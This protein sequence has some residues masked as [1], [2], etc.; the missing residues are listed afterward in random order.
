MGLKI[1]VEDNKILSIRGDEEDPFSKGHIC[2]KAVALQDIHEDPN[3][4]KHPM[5]RTAE[6]WVRISWEEAFDEVAQNLRNLREKYGNNALGIYKGNPSVHHAGTL[7][8]A[9]PFFRSIRSK[10]NFS[11]TSVDQLPH[12]MASLTMLGHQLLT[13]IPDIDRTDFM[14]ILGANPLVSNGSLMSAPGYDKRLKALQQRGGK[15]VVID[16]RRTETAKK[17]DQ[18]IFIKPGSDALLLLSLLQV[19]YA[20]NLI[21]SDNPLQRDD[22]R[23]GNNPNDGSRL[24]T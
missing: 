9:A 2:P 7:L 24:C 16:P 21:P 23:L 22:R 19:L 10:N 14:L 1:K 18:H 12:H 17:A 20:D 5:K 13:P 6:G 15:F 11:A 4:L 3:R 8:T